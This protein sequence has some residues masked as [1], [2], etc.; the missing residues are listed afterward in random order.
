M[1]AEIVVGIVGVET[2]YG[3]ITGNFRVLDAL[4]TLSFDF[5]SGRSDRSAF[6]R[7]ELEQFLVLCRREG[8]DPTPCSRAPSP[9]PW[10]CRS[11]CP[12]A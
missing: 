1:P 11:S 3:R 7:A 10:G 9:A 8:W 4:A 12:A 6:F 2:F 5:P